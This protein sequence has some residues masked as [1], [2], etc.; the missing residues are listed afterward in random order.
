[1]GCGWRELWRELRGYGARLL[2]CRLITLDA[3]MRRGTAGLGSRVLGQAATAKDDEPVPGKGMIAQAHKQLEGDGLLPNSEMAQS[4][5][6]ESA[7]G[8]IR[9]CDL[10]LR[11]RTLYPL[12]Y[13]RNGRPL[14]GAAAP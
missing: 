10:P 14:G 13:G 11:R 6:I 9:T 8:K 2:R 3:R 7:P 1:M 12:S 5:H 4:S